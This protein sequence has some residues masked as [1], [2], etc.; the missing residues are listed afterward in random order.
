MITWIQPLLIVAVLLLLVYLLRSRSTAQAKAWVKLGFVVFV[1]AGIYAI[2]RPND[3][4]TL[5]HWLGLGRGTDLM[6]Y[7]LIIA[8]AFTTLSTY[9]RFKDLELRYS[10]LARAVALRGAE[11]PTGDVASELAPEKVD[12]PSDSVR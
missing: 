6:L 2:L 10:R 11:P 12:G 7:A 4:T 9:L 5:A 1:V 3:T 8:F